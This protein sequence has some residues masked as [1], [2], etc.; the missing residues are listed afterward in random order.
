MNFDSE[1]F[2]EEKT[3]LDTLMEEK[4]VEEYL[5]NE[6]YKMDD[7]PERQR[8][9]RNEAQ[10]AFRH[11]FYILPKVTRTPVLEKDVEANF[12]NNMVTLEKGLMGDQPGYDKYTSAEEVRQSI[13]DIVKELKDRGIEEKN[14]EIEIVG[15]ASSA[16]ASDK[17]DK[18][19]LKIKGNDYPLDHRNGDYGGQG[20]NNEY[21]ASERAKSIQLEFKKFLPNVPDKN[22]KVSHEIVSGGAGAE[23]DPV[24]FV[25][26]K[27]SAID[28]TQ[29]Q[30]IKVDDYLEWEYYYVEGEG[31]S[32]EEA[33]QRHIG[34]ENVKTLSHTVTGG[35]Y[36]TY[37]A[38]L[39]ISFG[40][41]MNPRYGGTFIKASADEDPGGK[42]VSDVTVYKHSYELGTNKTPIKT[43]AILK[44]KNSWGDVVTKTLN[45]SNKLRQFLWSAG[46]FTMDEV[47]NIL[48]EFGDPNSSLLNSM[49]GKKG[50]FED[51]IKLAG[52]ETE[53]KLDKEH[54]KFAYVDNTIK[55]KVVRL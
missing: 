38:K 17:P 4:M 6:Q 20:A 52:G 27:I 24:R 16:D 3:S 14:I 15:T 35:P 44:N 30:E 54:A 40:Q 10:K 12:W 45:S 9:A 50:N 48:K 43:M 41:N 37:S 2:R 36:K 19:L 39:T 8:N 7:Y 1:K 47:S 55:R 31:F 23:G 46:Y 34:D 11:Y 21:L 5:L 51:F 49:K 29:D 32:S 13:S 22:F 33:L 28:E 53:R 42:G 18:R 26:V 25:K